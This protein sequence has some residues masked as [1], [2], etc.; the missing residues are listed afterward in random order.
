M[1]KRA[2]AHNWYNTYSAAGKFRLSIFLRRVLAPDAAFDVLAENMASV[3]ERDAPSRATEIDVGD[4]QILYADPVRINISIDNG[5]EFSQSYTIEP[6]EFR[7]SD[8]RSI[9]FEGG[10]V[11]RNQSGGG[12]MVRDPP[13][14]LSEESVHIPVIVTEASRDRSV[15]GSTV[16]IRG[17]SERRVVQVTPGKYDNLTIEVDS[18]RVEQWRTYLDSNENVDCDPIAGSSVGCTID[19]GS[20]PEQTYVVFQQIEVTLDV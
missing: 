17:V 8:D 7:V 2:S 18:P 9:F 10:A 20:L 3:Y 6:I 11:I 13:F 16:F 5:S 14:L 4:G 19:G 15:G 12:Y 1:R